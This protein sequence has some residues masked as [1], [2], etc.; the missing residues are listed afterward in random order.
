M[1]FYRPNDIWCNFILYFMFYENWRLFLQLIWYKYLPAISVWHNCLDPLSDSGPEATSRPCVEACVKSLLL[2]GA[3]SQVLPPVNWASI[4][5]PLLRM[6][7]GGSHSHRLFSLVQLGCQVRFLYLNLPS[8]GHLPPPNHT[9]HAWYHPPHSWC[10]FCQSTSPFHIHCL[11]HIISFI[12]PHNGSIP[13]QPSLP[14][15]QCDG[16]HRQF[17]LNYATPL[18]LFLSLTSLIR[19]FFFSVLFYLQIRYVWWL[20]NT[21]DVNSV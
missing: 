17:S 7:F 9:C 12:H 15:F 2:D 20:D 13:A 19:F 14:H 3:T 16:F 5:T 6:P 11:L 18:C 8:L 1:C 4:L 21:R 10:S